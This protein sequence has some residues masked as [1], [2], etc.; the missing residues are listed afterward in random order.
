MHLGFLGWLRDTC[1]WGVATRTHP[2]NHL[3]ATKTAQQVVFC[4][5]LCA[6]VS[7]VCVYMLGAVAQQITLPLE[8]CA[9]TAKTCSHG[10][11]GLN[12]VP[13]I[14]Q[15]CG[16]DTMCVPL[17]CCGAVFAGL[18]K[19]SLRSYLNPQIINPGG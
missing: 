17:S 14:T 9:T 19:P 6:Y 5:S 12:P 4:V 11:W 15:W 3:H 13:R 16:V 7:A 10:H 2:T 18:P 8:V 1:V